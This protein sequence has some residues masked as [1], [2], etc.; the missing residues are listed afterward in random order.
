M[1]V[2]EQQVC[3]YCADAYS[4]W[5]TAELFV[6]LTDALYEKMHPGRAQARARRSSS[7]ASS[8]SGGVPLTKSQRPAKAKAAKRLKA[9]ESEQLKLRKLANPF[10]VL[11]LNPDDD[12]EDDDDPSTRNTSTQIK[13][14]D[15]W[16]S[17]DT[18]QPSN[19]RPILQHWIPD[20]T[21][22]NGNFW[23]TYLNR[24]RVGSAMTGVCVLGD[25]A[26]YTCTVD[27][28]SI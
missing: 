27:S 15:S 12:S 18:T 17:H 13:K 22:E 10:S 23:E 19:H 24:L 5:M 11:S 14:P 6:K 25:T 16:F 20:F 9:T 1:I 28:S 8:L 3:R 26:G 7:T 2:S 4:G 21:S